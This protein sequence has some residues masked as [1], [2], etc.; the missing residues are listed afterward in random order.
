MTVL[1]GDLATRQSMALIRLFKQM[2][3]YIVAENKQLL[4]NDGI[5]QIALQTSQYTRD[6]AEHSADIAYMKNYGMA[7][8]N[9]IIIDNFSLRSIF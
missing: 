4:G 3:D 7:K 9:I 6:I 5:A 8:K 2:K 1:K